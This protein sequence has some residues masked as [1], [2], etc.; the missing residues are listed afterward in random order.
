[1]IPRRLTETSIRIASTFDWHHL[2]FWNNYNLAELFFDEGRSND[3]HIHIQRAESHAIDDR[4]QLGRAVELQA[5]F[6]CKEGR[7]E[8]AKSEALRAA[9][10][11]EG[12]GATEDV[13]DC[14]TILRDIE[15]KMKTPVGPRES[16][17]NGIG[18]LLDTTL[19]LTPVNSL[20]SA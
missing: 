10:V 4:Y 6:W 17:S 15:E 14:K 11:Y 12:I 2:L 19:L 1:M 13:E 7:F 18:E 20:F 9:E 8:E 3:A 5:R 16:D